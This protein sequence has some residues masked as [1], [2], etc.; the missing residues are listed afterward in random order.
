LTHRKYGAPSHD[1]VL[2][3]RVAGAEFLDLREYAIAQEWEVSDSQLWRYVAK[4]DERMQAAMEKSRP[5]L[6]ARHLMQRRLLF[7]KAL[8]TGD[9]R[10]AL[11]A[12]K[13]EAELLGLY[14]PPPPEAPPVPLAN[15]ADVAQAL[16]QIAN[17]L[18]AGHLEPATA[19][20]LVSLLKFQL[21]AVIVEGLADQVDEL[22]KD[23]ERKQAADSAANI[24]PGDS[25]GK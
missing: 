9:W 7:A 5:K 4:S 20:A 10:G 22:G 11:A 21:D 8:E 14:T 3:L 13:D 25:H 24:Y 12:L 17:E 23:L 1:E 18:R 6:L 16:P 19:T 2:R 15:A